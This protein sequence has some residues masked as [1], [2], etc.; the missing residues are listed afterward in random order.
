M[1]VCGI[2]AAARKCKG[3]EIGNGS[4][5]SSLKAARRYVMDDRT[6]RSVEGS[7]PRTPSPVT[8]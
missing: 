7:K 6:D 2:F 1:C 4:V 3:Y 8:I 5:F